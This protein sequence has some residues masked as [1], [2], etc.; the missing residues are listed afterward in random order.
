MRIHCTASHCRRWF[1][2]AGDG[3][4]RCPH[5]GRVYRRRLAQGQTR[6]PGDGYGVMIPLDRVTA[7]RFR[8]VW[9]ELFPGCGYPRMTRAARLVADRGG[10]QA[11][12]QAV[13]AQM[14][15]RG[16]QARVISLP[17]ARQGRMPITRIPPQGR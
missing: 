6:I 7:Y 2:P 16:C 15:A 17:Q 13:C 3:P 4:V 10:T 8:Q 11:Q 14:E 9:T 12:A 5:C 1:I